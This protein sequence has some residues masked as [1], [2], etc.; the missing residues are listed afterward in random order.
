MVRVILVEFYEVLP[1]LMDQLKS[2]SSKII[3]YYS[4]SPFR[5]FYR[6]FVKSSAGRET[7]VV[8]TFFPSSCRRTAKTRRCS[9]SHPTSSSKS[10]LNI[11]SKLY[12]CLFVWYVLFRTLYI[13]QLCV[14]IILA[15]IQ[16]DCSCVCSSVFYLVGKLV[17]AILVSQSV[18]NK[19]WFV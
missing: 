16:L 11:P 8:S 6:R 14:F 10:N 7:V 15:C 19:Q 4:F 5:C 17:S 2:S 9:K 18:R 13:R 12:V 1:K 3:H